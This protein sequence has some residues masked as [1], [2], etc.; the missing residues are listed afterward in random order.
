MRELLIGKTVPKDSDYLWVKSDVAFL[1]PK[2]V[3][4][5]LA[6][7]CPHIPK[8]YIYHQ[9]RYYFINYYSK[10]DTEIIVWNNERKLKTQV[11]SNNIS[12][13]WPN[14]MEDW[15]FKG[16]PT[17]EDFI[18]DN[19]PVFYDINFNYGSYLKGIKKLGF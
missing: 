8:N 9:A 13:K 17:I 15:G 16:K 4:K 1:Y 7:G 6:D 10:E 18:Y 12:E 5:W 3:D 19:T 11:V 14:S 2:S